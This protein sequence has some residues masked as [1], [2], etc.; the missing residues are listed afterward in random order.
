LTAAV[1]LRK[2]AGKIAGTSLEKNAARSSAVAPASSGPPLLTKL[3]SSSYVCRGDGAEVDRLDGI[4]ASS[5][6]PDR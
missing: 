1:A 3:I 4:V 5:L 6:L 2:L